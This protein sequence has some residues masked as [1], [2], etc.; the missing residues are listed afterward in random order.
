MPIPSSGTRH[1]GWPLIAESASAI[2]AMIPPS[3]RLSARMMRTTYLSDT[4]I[5]S[6]QNT[7]DRPPRMLAALSA[8]PWSGEKVSFTA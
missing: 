8:M 7:V 4:T 6:A 5:I 3:P 1:R 2:S